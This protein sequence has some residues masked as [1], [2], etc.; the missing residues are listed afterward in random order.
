MSKRANIQL[1]SS[2]E[3]PERRGNIFIWNKVANPKVKRFIPHPQRLEWP[4]LRCEYL[5]TEMN[6][7][8]EKC[9]RLLSNHDSLVR[10]ILRK[11]NV[12]YYFPLHIIYSCLYVVGRRRRKKHII[13]SSSPS[14]LNRR[15]AGRARGR[16][17][18]ESGVDRK[19]QN[20]MNKTK[21]ND[22]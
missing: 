22:G 20:A 16:E 14:P 10:A 12:F 13:N 11:L 8:L 4:G 3:Q 18:A 9:E 5:S 1:R 7:E 15:R 19:K 2:P 17:G 6:F 21:K